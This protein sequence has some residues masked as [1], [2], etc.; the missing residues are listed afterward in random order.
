MPVQS[1]D[2]ETRQF[3]K[4]FGDAKK[5]PA[6][7]SKVVDRVA[8]RVII[9]GSGYPSSRECASSE[10]VE[11]TKKIVDKNSDLTFKVKV[12]AIDKVARKDLNRLEVTYK[13]EL[14]AAE[15]EMAEAM[16][17]ATIF[18]EQERKTA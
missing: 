18:Q 1:R 14:N 17:D 8:I 5:D 16:K 11:K 3:K 2:T 13:A 9:E 6:N 7:V 10:R 15:R 12:A 4:F